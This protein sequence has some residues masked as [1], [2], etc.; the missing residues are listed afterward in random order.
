M[1]IRTGG[2]KS[3]GARMYTIVKEIANSKLLF[4]SL[5]EVKYRNN[6]NKVIS[7]DTGEKYKFVWC[8]MK[9]R[10]E[11]GVA[12]VIKICEDVVAEEPD[13]MDPRIMAI[14]INVKGFRL[15]VVNAYA[16]T[17]C[18]V[19]ESQKDIFYRTLK[20]A[21]TKQ[22][23]HQKLIVHG[24]F[25][26]TTSLS[27]QQCHFDGKK[28]IEDPISNENGQRLKSFCREKE[29]CMSQTY[30]DYP[31]NERYTWY[32]GDKKT[33]KVLDYVL[34]EKF[35]Q[36]Y[37]I[38]CSVKSDCIIE[39]DH[40][41]LVTKMN[42]PKTKKARRKPK[43]QPKPPSKPDINSLD[44]KEVKEKFINALTAAINRTNDLKEE[45]SSKLINCLRKTTDTTL[46]KAKKKGRPSEIWKN[47]ERLNSLLAER[48]PFDKSTNEFQQ[49]TKSIKK[50]INFLKNEK[51]EK[52]AEEINEFANQKK[53]EAL[54]RSFKSDNS[55]FTEKKNEK[56]CDLGKLRD[57][58][59]KHF[60]SNIIVED[61][62]ELI[63][64]PEFMFELQRL[65]IKINT[66]PP[67]KKELI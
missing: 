16:P 13:Y 43:R 53:V 31:I 66:E 25:N 52:E 56:R 41:L 11:A 8:G 32:S 36:E 30:F 34:V 61:P 21:C 5:Q 23:K 50:R 42:T 38:D 49:L 44:N 45:R 1:N 17:N 46:P 65:P 10:R 60:T 51:L 48:K 15:R 29:L 27:L 39:S 22:Y 47:D 57:H 64:I 58:F 24:D 19:S 62:I 12:M 40:R 37:I 35:I 18:D 7:L 9:K 55:S 26:A 2:E 67:T 63:D 54:Y 20:K 3:E 14:N 59:K 33:K 28:I 6:G 4:C